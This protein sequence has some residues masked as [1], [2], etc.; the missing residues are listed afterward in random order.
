MRGQFLKVSS[1]LFCCRQPP[2]L[3]ASTTA[4]LPPMGNGLDHDELHQFS[5]KQVRILS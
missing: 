2:R 3:W 5:V 4:S 1:A